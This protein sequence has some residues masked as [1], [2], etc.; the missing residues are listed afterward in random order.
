LV[1][2]A[3]TLRDVPELTEK[4]HALIEAQTVPFYVG[5]RTRS[6]ALG[7]DEPPARRPSSARPA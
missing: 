5:N 7:L 2:T 1:A 4:E 3:D 6:T